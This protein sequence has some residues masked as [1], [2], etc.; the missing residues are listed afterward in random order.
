[1]CPIEDEL[2]PRVSDTALW[3]LE[4]GASP[5][6]G[7][8]IHNGHRLRDDVGAAMALDEAGRLREEDPFTEFVIRDVPNRVVFHR[9][10]FEIDLNRDRDGAVYVT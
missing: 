10:R 8:A 5:I 9:S 6:V 1:M 7:T 4:R 3:S 2:Y